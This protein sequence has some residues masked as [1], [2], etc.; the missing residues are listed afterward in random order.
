MVGVSLLASA[1][2]SP[3]PG[4]PLRDSVAALRVA[5]RSVQPRQPE[6]L[7]PTGIGALDA[8]LGGG[9]LRGRMSELS[10][11]RSAGRTA[12]SFAALAAATGRGETVAL[13]DVAGGLDVARARAAGIDL[14]RLLWV[15]A[16]DAKKGIQAADLVLGAGGFGLVVLDVGETVPRLSDASWL[17]LARGAEKSGA[18]LLVVS[19]Q[20]ASSSSLGPRLTGTF[21]ALHLEVRGADPVFATALDVGGV[22]V[23]IDRRFVD[24]RFLDRPRV[25]RG[26]GA[27]VTLA[28]SKRG[29]EGG[30]ASVDLSLR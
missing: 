15:R 1:R 2:P 24:R 11:R 8:L 27:Q 30:A 28:R 29:G 5:L 12:L 9:L 23:A 16:G 25:L 3:S 18:A 19:P 10:G 7:S 17:R 6:G 4:Q 20:P 13:V 21:A 14:S 26:R 22:R